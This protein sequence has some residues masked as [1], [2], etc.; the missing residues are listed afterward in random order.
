MKP[1]DDRRA[2]LP[3]R[4]P[5]S[6]EIDT[7]RATADQEVYLTTNVLPTLALAAGA[8]YNQ[9]ACPSRSGRFWRTRSS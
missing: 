6:G 3:V 5:V 4:R 9:F 2:D 7:S 1:G 8:D